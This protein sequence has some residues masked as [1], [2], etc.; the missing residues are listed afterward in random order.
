MW[1]AR[2]MEYA[3]QTRVKKVP[4]TTFKISRLHCKPF[5]MV[6]RRPSV[7]GRAQDKDW[8]NKKNMGWTNTDTLPM[9]KVGRMEGNNNADRALAG[10]H[11][12]LC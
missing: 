11:G 12:L 6:E 1:N 8:K 2:A 10:T 9:E 5:Q 7:E 3:E 4:G